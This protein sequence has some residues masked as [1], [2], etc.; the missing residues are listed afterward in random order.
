MVADSSTTGGQSAVKDH[1]VEYFR[2]IQSMDLDIPRLVGF[3]ISNHET[4]LAACSF[5]S[6]AIIGSAF[7]RMLEE[8]GFSKAKIG[9]FIRT[10][11]QGG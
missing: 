10:I 4:F 1:Q 7:I 11:R 2:R 9:E 8:E 3:G 5:A 6:G